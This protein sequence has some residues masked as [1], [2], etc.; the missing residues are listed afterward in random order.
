M[1]SIRGVLIDLSYAVLPGCAAA[2]TKLLA[3]SDSGVRF[4]TNTTTKS[5]REL[6]Q[7]LHSI[8]LENV[9]AEHVLTSGGIARGFLEQRSLRPLLLVDP[10]LEEE[11]DGLDRT[12][13][14]AVVVGLAPEHFHYSKLNEAFRVLLE[15]GSLIALHEARYFAGKDGLNIGPGAFVKALEFSAGVQATIIG[16]PAP[17]FYNQA[18]TD[19]NVAP[20][21]AVMI[22]DDVRQDVHGA[23]ALG[24]R[25]VLVQTGKYRSGDEEKIDPPPSYVATGFPDAVEWIL[26]QNTS[27]E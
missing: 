18:L 24:L 8:G 3:Q 17:T 16:K 25:G 12:N 9:K 7:H 19:L 11:F 23:M 2:L 22:G 1:T 15:G 13:P 6:I 20:A 26:K 5:R 4:V 14:N 27:S 21:E 10:S